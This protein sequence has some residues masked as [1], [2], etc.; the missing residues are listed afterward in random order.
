MDIQ[1]R[2]IMPSATAV[3]TAETLKRQLSFGQKTQR[4]FFVRPSLFQINIIIYSNKG[5]IKSTGKHFCS[6]ACKGLQTHSRI[7]MAFDWG[8]GVFSFYIF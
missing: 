3:S 1:A 6:T 5:G 8:R 4:Q 2:N 7:R